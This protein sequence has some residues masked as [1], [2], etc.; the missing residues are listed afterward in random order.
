MLKD[1]SGRYTA[2]HVTRAGQISGPMGKELDGLFADNFANTFIATTRS[3][4]AKEETQSELVQEFIGNYKAANLVQFV[5][6]R[7]NKSF[8]KFEYSLDIKKPEKFRSAIIRNS[9]RIDQI[10]ENK[11]LY[12]PENVEEEILPG[13]ADNDESSSDS[14]M[15]IESDVSDLELI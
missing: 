12:E 6:N 13:V 5:R 10:G 15:E 7:G 9:K 3:K 1:S 14:E 11:T 2:Q 4:T 8:T